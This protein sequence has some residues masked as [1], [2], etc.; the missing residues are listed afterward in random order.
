MADGCWTWARN[1][2]LAQPHVCRL[3][4]LLGCVSERG[5]DSPCRQLHFGKGHAGRPLDG[6]GWDWNCGSG[7]GCA[8]WNARGTASWCRDGGREDCSC[9][10]DSVSRCENVCAPRSG[11][12][13]CVSGCDCGCGCNWMSG[14]ETAWGR[15]IAAS[16]WCGADSWHC[17]VY[18]PSVACKD[19]WCTRDSELYNES[20]TALHQATSYLASGT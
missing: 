20:H 7:W 8:T 4:A 5:S 3:R 19:T 1:E 10:C 18:S 14:P 15:Q 16:Y 9:D 2:A 6:A 11:G 12:C 17:V 13:G